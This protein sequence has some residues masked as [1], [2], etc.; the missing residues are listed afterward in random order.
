MPE[1]REALFRLAEAWIKVA[2]EVAREAL[3]TRE[4]PS[5][6]AKTWAA[7]FPSESESAGS[8]SVSGPEADARPSRC[9]LISIPEL[10]YGMLPDLADMMAGLRTGPLG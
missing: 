9:P 2:Q 6:R 5:R 7:F 10:S 1:H 8:A 4:V 3:N